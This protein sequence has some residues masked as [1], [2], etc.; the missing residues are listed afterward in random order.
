MCVYVFCGAKWTGSKF[1]HLIKFLKMWTP[2]LRYALNHL[3]SV[4]ASY[5]ERPASSDLVRLRERTGRDGPVRSSP[6]MH[7][8]LRKLL[9]LSPRLSVDVGFCGGRSG[10][11]T[12]LS[13]SSPVTIIPPL[14]HTHSF[15]F[16]RFCSLLMLDIKVK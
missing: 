11:G 16:H 8:G 7:C 5:P 10:T 6:E 12:S 13:R 14:L 9:C 4:T 1:S 2:F 15:T 3:P